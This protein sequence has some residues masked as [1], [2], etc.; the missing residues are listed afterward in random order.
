MLVNNGAAQDVD[1][2]DLTEVPDDDASPTEAPDSAAPETDA[3]PTPTDD[4]DESSKPTAEPTEEPTEEP[5]EEPTEEST[6]EP[7]PTEDPTE[8]A[9][10]TDDAETTESSDPTDTDSDIDMPDITLP[11]IPGAKIPDPAVPPKE[12]APYLQ[13]SDY[14]EGTVFIAVG[15]VL[16]FLLLA[17]IAWRL[18]VAWSIN[19]SVRRA[20]NQAQTDTAALLTSKRKKSRKSMY[21][22]AP[23]SSMSMEKL[24][25]PARNSTLPPRHH[26]PRSS[27]FFSP[28]AGGGMNTSGNRGSTYLPAGYYAAAPGNGSGLAHLSGS[29]I[30]LS[31]L[32]PQGLGYSRTKSMGTT[33]PGSPGLRPTSHDND[34]SHPST[35]SVNLTSAPQGRAPS[36]YLEDLFENHPP[37]R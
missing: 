9:E 31:P 1:L 23:G 3:D 20:N 5:S 8:D 4:E 18:L 35:S 37:G 2:P 14:P 24:G 33:P 13:E 10:T 36:A 7:T 29:S 16:G 12:G 19:R 22:Q 34:H 32:G 27:L 17:V 15:S 21:S 25:N 11:P 30:P 28:T 6:D 26:N